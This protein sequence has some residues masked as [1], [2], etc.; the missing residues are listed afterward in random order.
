MIDINKIKAVI[1]DLDGLLIDSQP[2]WE[3]ANRIFFKKYKL[4]NADGFIKSRK[5]M[6][7]KD[8]IIDV[9][10]TFELSQT[11]DELV[12][13]I[14]KIFYDVF[15]NSKDLSVMH[16]GD[17]FIKKLYEADLPLA[18]ATG[19]HTKER[20]ED[21]LRALHLYKYF[22]LIISSDEVHKGKPFPDV[23][24]YT[25]KKLQKKPDKCLVLEDSVPGVKAG[26]DAGMVVL[27]VNRLVPK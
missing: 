8:Y 25:A 24:L 7:L 9:K 5:G 3:D 13:D 18:I 12:V 4:T 27:G 2:S 20:V 26:K 17:V 6:G 19:G 16:G 11:I 1:F 10:N 15:L 14:R 22:S 23:Y 21:I